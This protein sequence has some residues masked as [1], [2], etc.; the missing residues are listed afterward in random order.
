VTAAEVLRL[1]ASTGWPV[2]LLII[3]LALTRRP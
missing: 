1:V 3:L 2:L